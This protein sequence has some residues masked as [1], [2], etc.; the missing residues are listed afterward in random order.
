MQNIL[1]NISQ[2]LGITIIHS[3]WQGMLIYLVLKLALLLGNKLSASVKYTL[4]IT[5]LSG[6]TGWFFYTLIIEIGLYKWLAVT[7][8]KLADMPLMLT[9]PV[10]IHQ[11]NEPV[12][13][14]YYSIE[15]YLLYITI[16]YAGGL[17]FNMAR[18]I[19]VRKRVNY[20]KQ[21]IGVD[22][23]I[24]IQVNRFARLLNINKVIRTGFSKL[25]DV[26]CMTGYFK[27]IILMPFTLST[28]LSAQEIE[29]IL[30]HELAHV[31]RND[32]LVN[33]AQQAI[34]VLLFFNPFTHLINSVINSERENC[35]DDLVVGTSVS[36]MVY[37]S[38]LL[39]LEQS[40]NHNWQLTLA[41]TGK[42]YKLLNRIERIMKTKEQIVKV[43]PALV[44]M[45]ILTIAIGCI[46]L[47]KPEIAQG[48]ISIK[49]T[50]PV[51][52]NII[53][54]ISPVENT[55]IQQDTVSKKAI[56][57]PDTTKKTAD[58]AKK[59][60]YSVNTLFG[61]GD[62]KIDSLWQQYRKHRDFVNGYYKTDYYLDLKK[63][64]YGDDSQENN[65]YEND[66][67]KTLLTALKETSRYIQTGYGDGSKVKLLTKQQQDLGIQ[68][69]AYY[70]SREFKTL[71][72]QLQKKYG[73]VADRDYSNSHEANY[74]KYQV[75]LKAAMPANIK[76]GIKTLEA[77]SQQISQAYSSPE[78]KKAINR[79]HE[80]SDSLKWYDTS[81]P[82]VKQHEYLNDNSKNTLDNLPADVRKK[83][84]DEEMAYT[85]NPEYKKEM[86][87]M[88]ECWD[89]VTV[90]MRSPNY[91]QRV[92]AWQ[93]QLQ[94]AMGKD[95]NAASGSTDD[96]GK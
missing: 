43:R 82:H 19:I 72:K 42:K 56:N 18:L 35:C 74:E 59:N 5:S 90:Y 68:V 1:F 27:P 20:I 50:T 52:H 10:D 39:K 89:K 7:P 54:K 45:F 85:N 21:N 23:G 57:K 83:Y 8:G 61:Y 11:L 36:P 17:L 34:G 63:K 75:A 86:A 60:S 51:I 55:E 16:I 87:L 38:A 13:R 6:I 26:P 31:K 46:A 73:I 79:I 24:Q 33:I 93:K 12:T 70:S 41:A 62:P 77:M 71:N 94:T 15:K 40:R 80:I 47:L 32:Y 22:A 76:E 4:A 92:E 30:L 84:M 81:K 3:L 44:A 9:L 58:T 37:A 29:A 88:R 48:K 66:T 49:A 69:G 91:R 95:Y 25:V 2:V 53:A 65:F 78:F 96:S 64:L 28:Y 67:L 14:Y